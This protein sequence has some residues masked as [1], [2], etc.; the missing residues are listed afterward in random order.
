VKISFEFDESPTVVTAIKSVGTEGIIGAALTGLMIMLFLGDWRSVIVVVSNI[1]LALMG[2]LFGLYITGNSIN[3][4]S[5]GGLAL[6]IGIL[7]DEATVEVEN[8][9]AQFHGGAGVYFVGV[10]PRVHHGRSPAGAVHAVGLGGGL[11]DDQLVPALQH[12]CAGHGGVAFEAEPGTCWQKR[13][14]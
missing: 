10:H 11:R 5:L 2:S 3:I 14:V 4:M 13:V 6:A 12:L 1:P 7:V 9:H 8:I